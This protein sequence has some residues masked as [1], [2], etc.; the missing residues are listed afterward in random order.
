MVGVSHSGRGKLDESHGRFF[1]PRLRDIDFSR[2][3]FFTYGDGGDERFFEH[4]YVSQGA[5]IHVESLAGNIFRLWITGD[6]PKSQSSIDLWVDGNRGFTPFKQ[7]GKIV[8]LEGGDEIV[9]FE[10][11]MEWEEIGGAWFPIAMRKWSR[12]NVLKEGVTVL[13]EV[14]DPAVVLK[15]IEEVEV[16]YRLDFQWKIANADAGLAKDCQFSDLNL[17]VGTKYFEDRMRKRVPGVD[18]GL[19]VKKAT[20]QTVHRPVESRRSFFKIFVASVLVLMALVV[21]FVQRKEKWRK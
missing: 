1:V 16:E 9:G 2:S 11:L 20:A 15:K 19:P 12:S 5:E 17:P 3:G 14:G 4:Y 18:R 7:I 8:K 10:K 13:P 21:C 6:T